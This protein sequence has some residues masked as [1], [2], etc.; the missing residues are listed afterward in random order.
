MGLA[1]FIILGLAFCIFLLEKI[2]EAYIYWSYTKMMIVGSIIVI[3][4]WYITS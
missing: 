2:I 4:I 1:C 3:T